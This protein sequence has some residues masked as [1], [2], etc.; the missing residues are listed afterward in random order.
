MTEEKESVA[1]RLN[2]DKSKFCLDTNIIIAYLNPNN[3]FYLEAN[4]AITALV[5]NK[6][7]ILIPHIILGELIAHRN[8]LVKGK[9]CSIHEVIK[10]FRKFV[11]SLPNCLLGGPSLNID[12]IEQYYKKHSRH[13]KLTESGFA[14]FVILCQISELKNSHV[15]T[16]DKKMYQCG[17]TIFKNRIYYLPNKSGFKSDYA[18]LMSEMQKMK[19]F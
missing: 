17:K 19:K 10:I 9:K 15:L 16:C 2:S 13:T 14:D 18:R 7:L 3:E 4:T 6:V 11:K 12:L 1:E 8:L 5:A